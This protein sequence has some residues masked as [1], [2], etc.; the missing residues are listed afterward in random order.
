MPRNPARRE[1]AQLPA[2][3]NRRV[4]MTS[5]SGPASVLM[6]HPTGNQNVRN[7]LQG[8]AE[9]GLLAEF[10]TSI[11]WNPESAWNRFLPSSLRGQLMRRVFQGVAR[12]KVHSVPLR[13]TV[14]LGARG[15]LVE[16]L[17]CSGER[18]FS[19]I[20]M[21]R[22]FDGRV[23]RR[24][25]QIEVDAVYAYEGGALETFREARRRGVATLYDL[26]SG[27]WRWER[28]LMREEET[29]SPEL[30]AVIPKLLD[31]EAHL[32]EKDEELRLADLVLVASHHVRRT[33]AGVVADEK[34]VVVP[35]GA[36]PVRTRPQRRAEPRRP[37][38]VLF[39][40]IL[41]QRKGIGY[42]LK[43]IEML[44]PDVELTLIGQR[45]AP[46]AIVDK[47]CQRWRWFESVPHQQVLDLMM[48]SDVLVLPSLSEGFGLVVTE[49]LA[50]GLPVIVTP[51]VGASDL[52]QDGR[53]GFVVPICSSEAIAGRLDALGRDRELL[54]Q[55]SENAQMAAAGQPWEN[56]REALVKALG[57][58]LWQR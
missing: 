17:L 5:T 41:H 4:T 38:Q 31:S 21:Y 46:N 12:E 9:H 23:A 49:A 55:M 6:S 56:Y 8:L 42:L 44:G 40:G 43:A 13:E 18:T 28:D 53:E 35:Y 30:A 58:A 3:E 22:H 14:R 36:P 51:N 33:L 27:H 54:E 16:G 20:G 15:S 11:A 39:A 26:P 50:C 47:A 52:V 34:I 2:A 1:L 25:R 32:R 19:V 45:L 24:L 37:L 29:R 48:Q 10:W 57:V 7:A